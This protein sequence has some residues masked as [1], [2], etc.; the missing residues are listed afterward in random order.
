MGCYKTNPLK[1][2]LALEIQCGWQI[3][4]GDLDEGRLLAPM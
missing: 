3:G 4:L 1:M 2:N